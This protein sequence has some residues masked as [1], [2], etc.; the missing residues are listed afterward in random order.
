[1]VVSPLDSVAALPQVTSL[2]QSRQYNETGSYN[3]L[4]DYF[5]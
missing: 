2:Q 3:I 5:V 4:Y 1:M